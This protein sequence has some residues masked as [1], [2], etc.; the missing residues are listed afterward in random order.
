MQGDHPISWLMF[1]TLA[2][3][4]FVA[5]GLFLSFLRSRNNREIAAHSL[6]GQGEENRGPAV[7][8]A[9]AG[10]ELIG[11]FVIALIAMGLLT[12]GYSQRLGPQVVTAPEPIT[13]GSS[14][15]SQPDSSGRPEQTR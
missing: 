4:L 11:L 8:R 10:P 9:G 6:A 14:A 15:G 3:A 13:T 2:A 12:A 5:C 7:T 1:F